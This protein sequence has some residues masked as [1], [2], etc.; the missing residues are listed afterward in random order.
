MRSRNEETGPDQKGLLEPLLVIEQVSKLSPCRLCLSWKKLNIQTGEIKP[1]MCRDWECRYGNKFRCNFW[2][3]RLK[4]VEWDQMIS[5]STM[6]RF[7]ADG[8]KRAQH[9]LA[10]FIRTLHRKIGP[11]QYVAVLSCARG[12]IHFHLAYQGPILSNKF[13]RTIWHPLTGCFQTKAVTWQ[14]N[15][16]WYLITKN[17]AVL[18]SY[19]EDCKFPIGFNFR[20]IRTSLRLFPKHKSLGGANPWRDMYV[21]PI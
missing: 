20:R 17:A 6:I 21:A 18:P 3:K 15:H 14:F 1:R 19:K 16:A 4:R 12:K 2:I 9:A 13:V 5:L 11:F 10:E 8:I 7:S